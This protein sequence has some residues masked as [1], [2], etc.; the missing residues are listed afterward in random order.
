M[1]WVDQPIGV[2]F[3]IGTPW[4]RNQEDLAKPFVD[5][6]KNF[7]DAFGI[8]NYKIYLTGESY[9]GRYVP[10]IGSE[11]IARDDKEYFD[12]AGSLLYDP[13]IGEFAT[14]QQLTAYPFVEKF[15]EL[16]GFSDSELS[17]LKSLHHDCGYQMYLDTYMTFPPPVH[18]PQTYWDANDPKLKACD[19]NKMVE[20]MAF[21]KNPCYNPY[22]INDHCPMV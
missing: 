8:K 16:Y 19:I 14:G 5:W 4:V 9:A 12:V 10:Y 15:H 11:M 2:G 13:T 17:G 3:S 22:Q 7:Q 20:R 18:Q 21:N 1:L 6:F